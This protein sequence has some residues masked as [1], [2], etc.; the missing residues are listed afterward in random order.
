MNEKKLISVIV[1]IYKI[2][3]KLLRRCI[4]SIIN[5]TYT[6][7]EIIL[8]NDNSPD[9]S[10]K[11]ISEYAHHDN[12]IIIID[13][14]KNEVVDSV[15]NDGLSICH[16][17]Y[18]IFVDADDYIAYDR[19]EHLLKLAEDNSADIVVSSFE[20]VTEEG[21][22]KFR[23]LKPEKRF[24]LD[25]PH[26][27]LQALPYLEYYVWPK[28]FRTDV[29]QNVKFKILPTA[30]GG[31]V[32]FSIECFLK[33]KIMYTTSETSYK[34][35]SRL[36]SISNSEIS[37]EYI[38]TKTIVCKL[39]KQLFESYNLSYLFNQYYYM[40]VF[41]EIT[42]LSG[43]IA[44]IKNK[45]KKRECFAYLKDQF[46][47]ELRYLVPKNTIYDPFY[48][49]LFCFNNPKIMYFLSYFVYNSPVVL[50]KRRLTTLINK[51]WGEN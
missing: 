27:R 4:E 15:R 39:V 41:Q 10:K 6:N 47:K 20:Q 17:N 11:I 46:Y 45:F 32:L 40:T 7:L 14:I 34:Y 28:L 43:M 18:F 24:C 22:L 2:P 13:K 9:N 21:T 37:L 44:K 5:Q 19:I 3:D 8:I 30:T 26:D 1:P 48:R 16:G 29:F 12:R 23:S 51:K 50:I 31:D 49:V 42:L 33:A 36:S 25:I 35:V 38:D